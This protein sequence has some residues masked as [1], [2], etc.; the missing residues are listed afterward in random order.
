MST[1]TAPASAT[2]RHA[3]T[4][5]TLSRTFGDGVFARLR[6]CDNLRLSVLLSRVYEPLFGPEDP[7]RIRHAGRAG[8]DR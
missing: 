3:A 1:A 5:A 6:F 2:D 7:V 8:R 4:L